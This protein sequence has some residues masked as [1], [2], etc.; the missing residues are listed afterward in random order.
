M[1]E[2]FFK[3]ED[4][5]PTA[6]KPAA[7]AEPWTCS[8]TPGSRPAVAPSERFA[9]PG[10]DLRKGLPGPLSQQLRH[11]VSR[12]DGADEKHA[13]GV[14]ADAL[15]GT[16]KQS[17]DRAGSGARQGRTISHGAGVSRQEGHRDQGPCRRAASPW[18]RGQGRGS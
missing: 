16:I 9:L 10:D 12:A 6:A 3:T 17:P 2:D 18:C 7:Q 15:R 13:L 5:T 4:A 11:A 1:T 14:A 8:P